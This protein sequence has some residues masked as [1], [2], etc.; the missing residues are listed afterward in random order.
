MSVTDGQ[1]KVPVAIQRPAPGRLLARGDAAVEQGSRGWAPPD[2]GREIPT[3]PSESGSPRPAARQQ[4][5][6]G[7]SGPGVPGAGRLKQIHR[8]H[9]CRLPGWEWGLEEELEVAGAQNFFSSLLSA[10]KSYKLIW[11]KKKK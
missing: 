11:S 1:H 3:P 5:G 9:F 4:L 8:L 10:V 2:P 7:A 6:A